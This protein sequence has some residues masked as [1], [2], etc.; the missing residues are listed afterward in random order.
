MPGDVPPLDS[1]K[2]SFSIEVQ[3][4]AYHAFNTK[5]GPVV[6]AGRPTVSLAWNGEPFYYGVIDRD[7]LMVEA[8]NGVVWLVISNDHPVVYR[9]STQE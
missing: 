1:R 9:M 6:R 5:R 4:E 7:P 3:H 2:G 8:R